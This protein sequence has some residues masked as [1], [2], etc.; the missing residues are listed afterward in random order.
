MSV[1]LLSTLH[2]PPLI[3]LRV[4]PPVVQRDTKGIRTASLNLGC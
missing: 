1:N 2:I 4:N 3:C